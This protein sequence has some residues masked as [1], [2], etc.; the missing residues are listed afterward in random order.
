MPIGAAP[1]PKSIDSIRCNGV[2][3][4]ADRIS[5]WEV[6]S[7]I[8]RLACPQLSLDPV[9]LHVLTMRALTLSLLIGHGNELAIIANKLCIAYTVQVK[10]TAPHMLFSLVSFVQGPVPS[11]STCTYLIT[12]FA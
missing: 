4:T 12:C 7:I 6:D 1:L 9:V 5:S 2:D 3:C 8:G 11:T 10:L